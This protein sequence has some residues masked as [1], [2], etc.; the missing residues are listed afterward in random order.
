[1]IKLP[2]IKTEL[3]KMH[4][5]KQVKSYKA[6]LKE[7]Y[8][9]KQCVKITDYFFINGQIDDDKVNLALIGSPKQL[10]NIIYNIEK[11]SG[12]IPQKV[13]DKFIHLYN[14]FTN[15]ILGKTF[16]EELGI[17]TCPYCNRS[18]IYTLDK[19]SVRP[20]YDHFFNKNRYPYLAVSIYNL[21]S[22]PSLIYFYLCSRP[23]GM[24]AITEKG[25]K[26]V[27]DTFEVITD[28]HLI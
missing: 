25:H 2:N 22:P 23:R 27:A 9:S 1:M 10:K 21:I 5:K 6:L 26:K 17:K 12:V 8:N 3:L 15:R 11:N 20:Q 16:C 18:Y 13:S 14:N 7:L 24:G 28:L 4:Y 19:G